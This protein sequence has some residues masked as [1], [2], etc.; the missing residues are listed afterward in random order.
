MRFMVSFKFTVPFD[1][2]DQSE[3]HDEVVDWFQMIRLD[4]LPY[5][6]VTQHENLED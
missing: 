6:S 3:L 1:V 2:D 4:N 5:Y